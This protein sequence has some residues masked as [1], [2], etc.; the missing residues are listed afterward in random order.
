MSNKLERMFR[1][2]AAL[3]AR[4]AKVTRDTKV[5][6]D[7][8]KA[9]QL[10]IETGMLQMMNDTGSE[11][12]KVKG[13]GICYI[14]TRKLPQAKDWAAVYNFVQETGSFDLMAKRLSMGGVNEYVDAHG[15][16]PPGITIIVER[17]VSVRRDT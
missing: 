14:S 7:K 5:I 9:Q 6:T 17:G 1:A 13:V 4:L 2:H 16:T 8:L 3:K 11:Q 15:D 12:L 10:L